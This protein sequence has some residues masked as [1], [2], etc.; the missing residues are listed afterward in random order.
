[1]E[2]DYIDKF[3]DSLTQEELQERWKK[4]EH[5]DNVGI[6]VN[7]FLDRNQKNNPNWKTIKNTTCPPQF[8]SCPF[9]NY[10][11]MNNEKVKCSVCGNLVSV[12]NITC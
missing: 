2:K 5:L 10:C 12:N 4:Y 6:T 9:T 3:F 11:F 7:D 1:M 8:G